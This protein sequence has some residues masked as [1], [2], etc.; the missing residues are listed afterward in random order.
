M[1]E[2]AH[3]KINLALHLRHRRADG[4]TE[5]ETVFAFTEFGDRLSATADARLSLA[6]AGRFA[7]EAGAGA[8]NLVLRAA[9][10]LAKAAGTAAGAALVLEKHIPVAAGLGGGSADAAAALRLLNR[11]WEL[12]WPAAR[13]EGIAAGL[14]S[15]VPACVASITRLGRGRG[16]I[17]SDWPESFSGTPVLLVNPGVA[18]PTGPV[19]KAWDGVDRGGIASGDSLGA[20]RN[21]MAAPAIGLAPAIAAVL[22]WLR[23]QPGAVFVQMSGSGATCLALFDDPALC[24]GAALAAGD[25]GLWATASTLR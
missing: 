1:F 3:A 13:L 16:E 4:F 12:H 17:L 14:G 9:S 23:E 11:L 21:D 15:D 22:E 25:K 2:P 8:D 5:L 20:F 6:V 18:V 10:A 7:S 19:F 24:E